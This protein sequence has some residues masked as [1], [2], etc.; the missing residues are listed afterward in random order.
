[1][2]ITALEVSLNGKAL[3]TVGM[4]GWQALGASINGHRYTKEMMQQIVAQKDDI[5]PGYEPHATESLWLMGHVGVPDPDRPGSSSG[6][7]YGQHRLKI[8]DE[9]TVRIIE[10]DKPDVPP[11]PKTGQGNIILGMSSSSDEEE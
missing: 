11:P 1:M 5:P 6:Q 3:Y 10:T 8:G 7:G 2:T 9:V 4:E